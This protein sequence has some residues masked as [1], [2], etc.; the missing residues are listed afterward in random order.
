MAHRKIT[1][2]RMSPEA[3][4]LARLIDQLESITTKLKHQLEAVQHMEHEIK[5]LNRQV[6]H[7]RQLANLAKEPQDMIDTD[8]VDQP[9][10]QNI[11]PD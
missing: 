10:D 7:W 3:R 9:D 1:L 5:S 2:R 8:L 6:E 4:K 11:I